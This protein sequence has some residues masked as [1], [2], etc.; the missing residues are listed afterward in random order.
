MTNV[1]FTKCNVFVRVR[2]KVILLDIVLQKM[3][4]LLTTLLWTLLLPRFKAEYVT[5]RH[6][7]AQFEV[8]YT[9]FTGGRMDVVAM[10]V[11]CAHQAE[12]GRPVSMTLSDHFTIRLATKFFDFPVDTFYVL[13]DAGLQRFRNRIDSACGT[14]LH[15]RDLDDMSLHADSSLVF[16]A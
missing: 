15:S 3:L 9:M 5:Y 1:R 4:L 11:K 8:E 2:K 14:S 10:T 16:A 13:D 12:S 7:N 6:I